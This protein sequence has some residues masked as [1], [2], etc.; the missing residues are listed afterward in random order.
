MKGSL[1]MKMAVLLAALALVFP[2]F[3]VITPS[4]DT[5]G[6]ADYTAITEAIAGGGTVELGEGTFYVNKQIELTGAVTL[7]GAG[8]DV[9]IVKQT[10]KS[11][12]FR[13]VI[14][15][16]HAEAVLEG[17]TIADGYVQSASGAG[18]IIE[19]TGGMVRDCRI[20]NCESAM[21]AS[22]AL[23]VLGGTVTRTIIDAN[24]NAHAY[25]GTAGVTISAGTMDNCLIVN[26]N[27]TVNKCSSRAYPVSGGVYLSGTALLRNCTIAGNYGRVV[28]GVNFNDGWGWKTGKLVN[29]IIAGN[30]ASEM[31]SAITKSYDADIN[32]NWN[33]N[34]KTTDRFENCLFGDGVVLPNDT[35][36]G[37]NPNF[38]AEGDYHI[39]SGSAAIGVADYADWMAGMVDLGGVA[40]ALSGKVDLG[41]YQKVQEAEDWI[42][43]LAD[44]KLY[45]EVTPPYGR[46][47]GLTTGQAI[48]CTAPDYS[49]DDGAASAT[50]WEVRDAN[51]QVVD[52][53]DGNSFTYTHQGVYCQIVWFWEAK[54]PVSATAASGGTVSASATSAAYGETVEVTAEP[55]TTLAGVS[56]WKWEGDVP[57]GH[58]YDNPLSLTVDAAKSV[59]A[60]FGTM[61]AHVASSENPSASP[62]F[63]FGSADTA[64]NTLAEALAV[65]A[66]GGVI[67]CGEGTYQLAAELMVDR[68]VTIRGAGFDK[69]TLDLNQQHFK[70]K[71]VG[72]LVEGFK[73][74][75]AKIEWNAIGGGIVVT[76]GT[77]SKCRFAGNVDNNGINAKGLCAG[78]TGADGRIT[79]CIFDGNDTT[80]KNTIGVLGMTAGLV[81]NCLFVTNKTR[82]GAVYLNGGTL[83]NCTISGNK[84]IKVEG[85]GNSGMGGGIYVDSNW[86]PIVENCLVYG[87]SAGT[88]GDEYYLGISFSDVQ[89]NH[90][91]NYSCFGRGNAL[92]ADAID[93]NPAL[94]GDY[95]LMAGSAGIDAGADYAGMNDD[96]DLGGDPRVVNDKVD[97]GC[98][99]YVPSTVFA[100]TIDASSW[101]G[102]VGSS[103]TLSAKFDEAMFSPT[104]YDFVWTVSGEGRE[105]AV[106]QV[107]KP[108]VTFSTALQ[109][110]VSL[111]VTEKSSG[112]I[113]FE[114][115][116][117]DKISIMPL[118][119]Y[120][121]VSN[122]NAAF[123]YDSEGTAAT[124]L[125]ELAKM[126]V[127]GCEVVVLEGEHG[128]DEPITLKNAVTIRSAKGRDRTTIRQTATSGNIR[129]LFLLDNGRAALEGLT[130]TGGYMYNEGGAAVRIGS[131]GGTVRDCR[132]TG[133]QSSMNSTGAISLGGAKARVTRTIIDN[134]VN[135]DTN[136][137]CPGVSLG[138]GVMDNCLI[139]SN[140]ITNC[141]ARK[142]QVPAGVQMGG[143]IMSNCTVTAN[144]GRGVGGICFYDG[145]N[146][147]GGKAVNCI[148]YGNTAQEEYLVATSPEYY[149]N[150]ANQTVNC[151]FTDPLF[152]DAAKLDFHL[153]KGSPAINAGSYETWMD[154]STDLDGNPRVKHVKR[155]RA[156]G[157]IKRAYVDLGCY[158]TEWR[159]PGFALWMK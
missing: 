140:R 101:S 142:F 94:D 143:G 71:A 79:H 76:A 41:C 19:A 110:A 115:G 59:R 70:L 37:G 40:F 54:F 147:K 60:I 134:N 55:D 9:T 74:T 109:Y 14:R 111:K 34:V 20:T 138:A 61:T 2:S 26:N 36:V 87:N 58:Q 23:A 22:G 72:A 28:G 64:A 73:V 137:N 127:D 107:Q 132:I 95:R 5:T 66:D 139:Y 1:D 29:C 99:E 93:A 53:G 35:C 33:C 82:R 75:G 4:G 52:S 146:W 24:Y 103:I 17:V 48:A 114:G 10:L 104:D 97:L 85:D 98:Y 67:I 7:K 92:G 91:A 12:D 120:L 32:V 13:R 8:R 15:L 77:V 56:F 154:A 30:T 100:C 69:T 150:N 25:G 128:I 136:G 89:K 49:G 80:S 123:P 43:V 126:L 145:Y 39:T 159:G 152:V 57:A 81:D 117:E 46:T 130:L 62:S 157:G 124:N 112:K 51:G 119:M 153:Q 155:F 149:A 88:S 133:N 63:P 125:V 68:P 21:N 86:G 42:D 65:T 90:L 113:V 158:E 45:G 106:E 135:H 27:L 102:L 131:E 121:A 38:K 84:A 83:R 144:F 31:S 47:F 44:P 50:R 141:S 18:V 156:T 105:I 148:V 129:R 151:L 16:N 96:V 108:T 122:P 11:G 78:V 3:A 116:A 6:A 118:T